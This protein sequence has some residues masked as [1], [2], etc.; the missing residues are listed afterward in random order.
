MKKISKIEEILKNCCKDCSKCE[1]EEFCK[2][3]FYTKI[4]FEPVTHQSLQK[5][6]LNEFIIIPFPKEFVANNPD[7]E[8]GYDL[9]KFFIEIYL[10]YYE[11]GNITLH[12]LVQRLKWDI[13]KILLMLKEAKKRK[14]IYLKNLTS[15]TAY[16]HF[17]KKSSHPDFVFV[18]NHYFERFKEKFGEK[19]IFR[20]A[21]AKILLNL[22]K[23][24]TP[25]VVC[26][27]IDEY[28]DIQDDFIKKTGYSLKFLPEKVNY[29]LMN[30]NKKI[31][32]LIEEA[33]DWQILEYLRRKKE[34]RLQGFNKNLIELYEREIKR[35]NISDEMLKKYLEQI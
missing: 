2:N 19:P 10:L 7:K 21:E 26:R 25:N 1:N 31:E 8:K 33:P 9:I 17:S 12:E 32:N 24:Y 4:I 16:L 13:K 28:L 23:Q 29:I 30:M 11:K 22:L 27:L 34:N 20:E 5:V 18:V 14:Y 3:S 6:D 35:R 15:R